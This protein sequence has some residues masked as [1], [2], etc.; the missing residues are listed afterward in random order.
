MNKSKI[1]GFALGPVAAAILGLIIVPITTWFFSSDDV[2]R[3]SI[4]QVV[5][6]FGV[7]FSV[8]GLDQAYVREFHE[9]K[10]KPKLFRTCFLP[11]IFLLFALSLGTS[12]FSKEIAKILYGNDDSRLYWAT[13]LALVASYISRFLSLILRMNERGLAFSISQVLPKALQLL[14]IVGLAITTWQK[15]FVS[16]V[17]SALISLLLVLGLYAWNTRKEWR[18]ALRESIDIAQLYRLLNFGFPLVF[19]GLAYWGLT[20]TGTFALRGLSNLSE[21]A[22][23]SVATSF[24]AGAA[25][26]QSIFSVI[27][28]PIVY[29]WVAEDADMSRVDI[30][31]HQMLAIMCTITVAYGAFSWITDWLLPL[32]YSQVKYLLL[33]CIVQPLLY[34]LS[35]ITAVG[36]TIT[37]RTV[38]S[39]WITLAAASANV[40]LSFSLVPALGATGAVIANALAFLIFFVGRTEVSAKIWRNLPRRRIYFFVF[41]SVGLSILTGLFS[42]KTPLPI[43]FVWGALIPLVLY[44]FRGEFRDLRRA[45]RGGA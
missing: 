44:F 41:L 40:A 17:L 30:V 35:E 45:F 27:W 16:L 29:K 36:I 12:F 13:L 32:Q 24:A 18:G 22:V 21:L 39:L 38:L 7:L 31:A 5:I 20:A 4:F 1:L 14:I 19:S 9:V 34:T 2:G 28:A 42:E 37:R 23:Y 43:G 3:L 15:N 10:E 26:F 6:S 25:I 33:C 8:L 11:G